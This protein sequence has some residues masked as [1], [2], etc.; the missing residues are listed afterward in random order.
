M[1]DES[2][3]YEFDEARAALDSA[4]HLHASGNFDAAVPFYIR[5]VKL[6]PNDPEVLHATGIALGQSGRAAEAV[7]HLTAALQFGKNTA[8]V[9]NALGM[10]FTELKK[11]GNA[12]RCFRQVVNRNPKS[13]TGWANFGN[14]A[15]AAGQPALGSQRYDQ[16]VSH[17]AKFADDAFVQSLIWLLRGQWRLGWKY[18]ETRREVGNWRIRNRQQHDLKAKEIT[19]KQIKPGMRILIEAEQG[20][21]DAVMAARFIPPFAELHKVEVVVQSHDAL[22]DMLTQALP[23]DVVDRQ[24]IPQADGWVPMLSL[25]YFLGIER[26]RDVGPPITPFGLQWKPPIRELEHS[27]LRVFLHT[28]GNTAHSYDFDRSVPDS[29]DVRAL[30]PDVEF[31]TAQFETIDGLTKEPTWRQ[32]VAQLLTC[33]RCLTVDTGLAHVAGS[34][35]I[36][37]DIMIPTMPEWRWQVDKTSTVWYPSAQLWRRERFDAW[38]PMLTRIAETYATL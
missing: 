22:K 10:A 6:A 1:S 37:T 23:Y 26:P 36:P 16:A 32:T 2:L 11:L 5:A 13:A 12:E 28:K 35:G 20:Q 8:D 14:F 24:T 29:V 15:Y 3:S 7:K 21:G 33:D 9:W 4:V 30:F 25:P 38:E 34:L 17:K 18:Y 31:V 19:R 27:K